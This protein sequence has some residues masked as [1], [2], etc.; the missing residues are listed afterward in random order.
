MTE[1]RPR[2]DAPLEIDPEEF[3]EL[4]RRAVDRVA[5]FLASV[6]DRKVTPGETPGQ[7]RKMLGRRLLP[8]RGAPARDLLESAADLLVEHSLFNGHPR[9]F[10]YITSSAAPIGALADLLAASVNPNVGAWALSPVA[11]EI[12]NETIKWIAQFLGLGASWGGLLVSGGN[13]ANL[14][15]F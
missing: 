15:A 11:T 5:D 7:V 10:G 12:E 2:R 9:F 3:R 1:S 8:E 13:V 6:R 4:G 14:V